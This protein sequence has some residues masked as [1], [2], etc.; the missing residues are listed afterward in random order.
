MSVHAFWHLKLDTAARAPRTIELVAKFFAGKSPKESSCD[1]SEERAGRSA[2]HAGFGAEGCSR[3]GAAEA[4][5]RLS[6]VVNHV[7]ES[8]AAS[9]AMNVYFVGHDDQM[10]SLACACLTL[11]SARWSYTL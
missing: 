3:R 10:D 7:N 8:E 1:C 9:R 11:S 2:D 5:C 4:S 6:A